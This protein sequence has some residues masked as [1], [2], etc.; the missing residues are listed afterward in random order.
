M[1]S[2]AEAL[3]MCGIPWPDADTDKV[4]QAADAWRAIASAAEDAAT[5]GNN[6]KNSIT[7]NNSGPAI[8]AF[9]QLWD[10]L[11]GK[12]DTADL[13]LL[14]KACGLLATACDQFADAVEDT[15]HKLE[16]I[17]IE[18]AASI[19]G[20]AVGTVLTLGISDAVGAAA[21]GALAATAAADFAFLGTTVAEIAGTALAGAI[22]AL[23]S[24]TFQQVFKN[25]AAMTMG[26]TPEALDSKELGLDVAVG[27]AAGLVSPVAEGTTKGA[28]M[29]A[30]G[31][32]TKLSDVLPQLPA[33][34]AAVPGALETPA[35]KALTDLASG[36]AAKTA[37]T[38]KQ[39]EGPDVQEVV[40]S[41]VA[42]EVEAAAEG[43]R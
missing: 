19:A 11:G 30:A 37:L 3:N 32:A 34:L 13:P 23:G 8:S 5:A 21:T 9:A 36:E 24:A 40:G 27:A 7:E 18:L 17:G 43:G 42:A 12:S 6:I 29:A 31:Q 35:G 14:V 33:M 38:G 20:A 16:T 15:K 25:A 2:F 26:D 41:V 39:P 4:R 22:V 28:A 1:V 10:A